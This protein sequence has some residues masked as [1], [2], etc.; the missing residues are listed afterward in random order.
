MDHHT[1]DRD[2]MWDWKGD[3]YSLL[4]DASRNLWNDVNENDD[5]SY[6]F[7]ES[8]TP[9]KSCGDLAYQVTISENV[10]KEIDECWEPSSQSKR[11]RML[12]FDDETLDV[13][14][15]QLCDEDFSSDILKS[16]E[17]E[18]SLDGAFA[19]MAQ[20][21]SG[22][23]DNMTA[24]A[25]GYDHTDQSS[26]DWLADCFVNE[27]EMHL[28]PDDMNISKISNI[29]VDLTDSHNSP[30]KYRGDM[31]QEHHKPTCRNITFKGKKSF[32]KTPTKMTSSVVLPFA[33]VKPCGDGAITLKDINQR[34]LTP[35][36]SKS[37]KT[38]EDP[39]LSYPTSAFSGKPIVGKTKIRTEGG[40][41]S[42]TIM[43]TRN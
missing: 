19:D 35:P 4:L 26:E 36:P 14:V 42:I 34:I 3:D 30:P 22:F 32:I 43:R 11:R 13:D 8:T 12:H 38:C 17:K 2:E 5:L 25:S 39:A 15:L 9:V 18:G 29:H 10:N 37:T 16:K 33:F 20:W 21:V 31:E 41:G 27:S 1:N 23:A 28:R 40:K 6:M 24:S 7:D